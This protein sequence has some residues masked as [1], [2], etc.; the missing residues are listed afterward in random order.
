MQIDEYGNAVSSREII[1]VDRIRDAKLQRHLAYAQSDELMR[2]SPVDRATRIARY[3]DQM[4]TPEQGRSVCENRSD[5]LAFH[6]ASQQVLL[7]DV[8]DLCGA[9]VCRHRALLFKLMADEASLS[10]N[11]V[12]G[13]FGSSSKLSGHSWNEL[14]LEDQ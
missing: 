14:L 6:Y 3:I 7:G 1:H 9:G 12:R 5:S 11:L 8:V 10:C 13:M 2:L 4:M